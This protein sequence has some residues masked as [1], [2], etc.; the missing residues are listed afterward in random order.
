MAGIG[1]SWTVRLFVKPLRE[2]LLGSDK[3][4]HVTKGKGAG[5]AVV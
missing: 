1:V 3:H 4:E 2:M 5:G